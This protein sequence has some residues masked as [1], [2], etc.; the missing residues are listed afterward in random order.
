RA[1][2]QERFVSRQDRNKGDRPALTQS[3]RAEAGQRSLGQRLAVD[4]GAGL[5]FV[6][7]ERGRQEGEQQERQHS[8]HGSRRH[9]ESSSWVARLALLESIQGGTSLCRL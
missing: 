8:L 7:E 4:V 9:G 1:R 6:R 3:R 2:C 5:F